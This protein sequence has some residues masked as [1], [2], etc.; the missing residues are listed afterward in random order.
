M[1]NHLTQLKEFGNLSTHVAAIRFGLGWLLLLSSLA[2]LVPSWT[3][4][5]GVDEFFLGVLGLSVALLARYSPRWI[6]PLMGFG[7]VVVGI[8]MI[9][10]I[11]LSHDVVWPKR[12]ALVCFV[13]SAS[14]P[15]RAAHFI[16]S[17]LQLW[18][19]APF[20][21]WGVLLAVWSDF[22]ATDLRHSK[23]QIVLWIVPVVALGFV[24]LRLLA[25]RLGEL[26]L[27]LLVAISSI[28]LAW[29]DPLESLRHVHRLDAELLM[30]QLNM[31]LT[32]ALGAGSILFVV[33]W[34]TRQKSTTRPFY[35]LR[36]LHCGA[37]Y[38]LA[39]VFV[40][41]GWRSVWG[42]C[43]GMGGTYTNTLLITGLFVFV[44]GPMLLERANWCGEIQ[45]TSIG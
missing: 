24:L 16:A 30:M 31:C 4:Y 45:D 11:S 15:L 21:F 35:L 39:P 10:L 40:C 19:L 25:E 12:I 42:G 37:I 32:V 20:L 22:Y 13:V 7:C 17:Q 23:F 8:G 29:L 26:W 28:L 6:S 41:M 5:S 43:S 9:Y 18:S 44:L 14:M 34:L 27:W 2:W 36:T 38:G 3:N 33:L 1:Q